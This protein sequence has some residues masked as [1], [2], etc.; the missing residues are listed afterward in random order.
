M[1]SKNSAPLSPAVSKVSSGV[2]E[3]L[4]VHSC[5]KLPQFLVEAQENGWTVVGASN[6]GET[7]PCTTFKPRKP[8][9]LVVGESYTPC[10][11]S[12]NSYPFFI[13]KILV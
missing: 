3:F 6:G 5:I 12:N 7:V 2:V 9:A 10:L 11:F 13:T 8:V 4:P 1:S